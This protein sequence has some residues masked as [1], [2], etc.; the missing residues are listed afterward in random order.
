MPTTS[1]VAGEAGQRARAALD[2]GDPVEAMRIHMRDIVTMPVAEVDALFADPR[3][4]A[5]FAS[6]AASQITDNEALDALGVGIE[7]FAKL[8]VPTTLVEGDTSPAHLR[9]RT[10]DLA[11]VL[12]NARVVTLPGQG[13]IAHMLAPG[14]LIELIRQAAAEA[15]G[16]TEA[17]P[18][19]SR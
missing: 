2:A 1:P 16:E 13:H 14:L 11:A 7:R 18:S 4:Q 17:G 3:S 5:Y 19:A 15:F 6:V 8:D 9:Q 12:P 10:A